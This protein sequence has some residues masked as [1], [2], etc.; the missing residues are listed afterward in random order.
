MQVR[1]DGTSASTARGGICL[2]SELRADAT[3][4]QKTTHPEASTR[5]NAP[6]GSERLNFQT[7]MAAFPGNPGSSSQG[8]FSLSFLGMSSR[9]TSPVS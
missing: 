2:P 8:R 4:L 6:A 9:F 7:E 5:E 3:R 1:F